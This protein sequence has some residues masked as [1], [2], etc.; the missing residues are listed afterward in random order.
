M[1]TLEEIN[2]LEDQIQKLIDRKNQL[3]KEIGD[4]DR[5]MLAVHSSS[6]IVREFHLVDRL[7]VDDDTVVVY[8]GV[9]GAYSHQ[10]MHD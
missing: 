10:A 4:E 2:G 7:K 1:G 6:D 5:Q 3:I 9:P 8:Q